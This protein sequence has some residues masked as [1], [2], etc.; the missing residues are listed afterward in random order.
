M[1]RHANAHVQS[2][3]AGRAAGG[4]ETFRGSAGDV[5]LLGAGLVEEVAAFSD[6]YVG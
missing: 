5:G 3:E 6:C 4:P 1:P 2:R